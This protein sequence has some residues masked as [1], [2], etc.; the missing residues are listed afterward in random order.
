M[1]FFIILSDQPTEQNYNLNLGQFTASQSN[2]IIFKGNLKKVDDLEKQPF[3]SAIIKTLLSEVSSFYPGIPIRKI[4]KQYRRKHDEYQTEVVK[5]SQSKTEVKTKAINDLVVID[6][7]KTSR[8]GRSKRKISSKSGREK[9]SQHER[10]VK[11]A[12]ESSGNDVKE[13]KKGKSKRN[14]SS[15]HAEEQQNQHDRKTKTERAQESSGNDV[16]EGEKVKRGRPKRKISSQSDEEQIEEEVRKPCRK[17]HK[18]VNE[19]DVMTINND[20]KQTNEGEEVEEKPEVSGNKNKR[21]TSRRSKN[22]TSQEEQKEIKDETR[23]KKRKTM[24][25]NS[26]VAATSTETSKSEDSRSSVDEKKA[27][28]PWT[29]KYQ[30][31]RSSEVMGNASAVSRLKSWLEEWKLR[32][33]KTL[34]KELEQQK[35]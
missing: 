2:E 16:K 18:E 24:P 6:E 30:P 12:Q 27:D 25:E 33:E 19:K 3:S 15:E 7:E 11:T 8:K 32:R 14:T 28:L 29:D 13:G 23:R 31:E 21:K 34:R 22:D 1:S 20:N 26:A 10:K 35:K 5:E 9:E 17:K 4:Y